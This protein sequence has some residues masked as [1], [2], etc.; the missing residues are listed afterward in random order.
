MTRHDV[1]VI[2]GG[3]AGLAVSREL[4]RR[5]VDHSV[6]ERAR[7]GSSWA[8]LW[9]NFRLN[10]PNWSVKLPGMPYGGDDPDGF[11]SRGEIVA[12]LERYVAVSDT[13]LRTGIDVT[14]LV[15][16]AGEVRLQTNEGPMTARAAVVC[17]GAYQRSF[18]PRGADELPPGLITL[19][20]RSYRT[21]DSVPDGVVLV[22][23]SGQS[24][25]QIAEELCDAGRE[26]V[27]ACGRAPRA[28]RRVGGHD[29]M[30][31]AVE[32]GFL[33]GTMDSLPA[34]AARFTA[35]VTASGADGGHDLDARALRAKGAVLVGRF[36]GCDGGR[37]RF[38]DD[39]AE[40]VAWADE[41][42]LEFREDVVALCRDRGLDVPDLP[43]PE[44]FDADPPETFDVRALGGVIFTG[45]F[46]PD[47]GWIDVPGVVDA[48][49]F[50]VQ[51]DGVSGVARGVFFAGV[52]FLRSRKSSLL[53]GI[54]D[55]A[56]VVADKVSAHV[57]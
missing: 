21:P 49:G 34:P 14:S 40:S 16:K 54:G 22:V 39:L 24:G 28:P 57:G 38:A 47:Y 32:T 42:Y 26:V 35:N 15:P 17:T 56:S 18:R 6:L 12:H 48:W 36:M 27:V 1:L 43:D 10:T 33:D 4:G 2:G 8:T 46:R 53:Y 19:D 51:R 3:Q 41:R 5:D 23:G 31:W 9:E 50:P 11:M 20:P 29:L 13:P 37:V 25:C 52:H 55:D 45:G 30:W 7:V 44:P